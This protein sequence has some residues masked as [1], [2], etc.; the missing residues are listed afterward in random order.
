MMVRGS[1]GAMRAGGGMENW[2]ME[3]LQERR[4]EGKNGSGAKE[5]GVETANAERKGKK[6]PLPHLSDL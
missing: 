5:Q 2:R 4:R 3:Q 1:W 6:L